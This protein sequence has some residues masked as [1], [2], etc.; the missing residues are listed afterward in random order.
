M[1]QSQFPWQPLGALLV[2]EGLM[3][4]T[5]VEQ[6]LREQRR[7]GRLLGEIVVQRGFV[8]GATLARALARQHCVE[9]RPA[10]G[11]EPPAPLPA[12]EPDRSG[13]AGAG[14]TWRPLGRVLVENGF[15]TASALHDALRA[16]AEEPDRRLGEI[17]FAR[18]AISGRGL[19][20][21]LAEQHGVGL[22][23]E[24]LD[25]DVET[26]ITATR[27]DEASYEVWGVAYDPAYE[28]RSV[29]FETNNFLEAADYACELVDRLQPEAV[30][31]Q[32]RLNGAGETVWT[33][34]QQRAAAV[35]ASRTS[36]T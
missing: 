11:V 15:V 30:E 18:G 16:Q 17:L 27:P 5:N 14:P 9:L 10:S 13:S 22:Q 29:L 28:R 36:R 33:Y 4:A 24:E 35:A 31:I 19:A 23:S 25:R 7:T 34:S 21:A 1:D 20:L 26:L 2:E 6:A 3:S 32:R 12:P 8:S